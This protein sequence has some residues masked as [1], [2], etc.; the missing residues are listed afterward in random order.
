MTGIDCLTVLKAL[1]DLTRV[2][3][4]RL[5]LKQPLGVNEIARQLKVSQY[6]VSKHLRI[7]CKAKLLEMEKQGRQHL[8]VVDPSLKSRLAADQNVLK[9]DCCSFYFDKL[10]K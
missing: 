2:R 6:N 1:S 10:P 3:I 8:Y 9:L 4:I 7:L 5:L